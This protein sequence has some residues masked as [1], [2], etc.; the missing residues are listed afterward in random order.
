VRPGSTRSRPPRK[1]V[2]RRDC[3]AAALAIAKKAGMS[4]ARAT[5]IR[6]ATTNV[7][8]MAS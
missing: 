6:V 2:E 7:I 1:P 4:L 8:W 3:R 5:L